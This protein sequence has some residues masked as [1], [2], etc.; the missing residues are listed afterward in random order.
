MQSGVHINKELTFA[1]FICSDEAAFCFN[2]AGKTWV[3][4]CWL[5]WLSDSTLK[6]SPVLSISSVFWQFWRWNCRN[7]WPRS[8]DLITLVTYTHLAIRFKIM[9]G[10][11]RVSLLCI[12]VYI[13]YVRAWSPYIRPFI[14]DHLYTHFNIGG[15]NLHVAGWR[16]RLQIEDCKSNNNY[17]YCYY[18]WRNHSKLEGICQHLCTCECRYR[19]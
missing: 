4:L 2:V 10:C 7:N 14:S 13:R 9:M 8:S 5:A 11:V 3:W 16:Y 18:H 17:C 6:L 15:C 12:P 1:F 19:L